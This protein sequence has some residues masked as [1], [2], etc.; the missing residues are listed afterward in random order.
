MRNLLLLSFVLV[1]VIEWSA[2][3]QAPPTQT[4]PKPQ[5]APAP[6]P[7]KTGA[8]ATQ[9]P[10]P[11]VTPPTGTAAPRRT[12]APANAR[13]GMAITAT[14]P[15]GATLSGVRVEL[16]GPTERGADTDGS[17][18]INFP[19]LLAG[20][21]RL[22]FSGERVTTFEREVVVRTGQVTPVDVSLNPAPEPRVIAA[23]APAPAPS[24]TTAP[25]GPKGQP[26]TVAIV[27]VLEKEFV[28]RQ[29]RRE[30]LL[31][32]SGNERATMIQLNEPMPERLYE[33]ADAVYYVLGGEGS[34]QMNGRETR[35][36]TNG[37]AS[38]PHGTSHTFS[39]RGNRSLVLLA[40]LSGEPCEQAR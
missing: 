26:L 30:S 8:P 2:Q 37:F 19:G 14:S 31:S 35:L 22:R 13:S 28:G 17:G 25:L 4:Q 29:P 34:I 24:P 15:Q 18:Q 20:T 12:P 21:Y 5:P 36:A 6:L 10:P 1:G 27:D 7:P 23:P 40:V 38:V 32:C 39:R 16:M 33:T 3:A 11:K 9:A